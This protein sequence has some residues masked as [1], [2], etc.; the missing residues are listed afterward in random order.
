MSPDEPIRDPLG[1]RIVVRLPDLLTVAAALVLWRLFFPAL[2]SADTMTQY[3]QALTRQYS[4]W[5]PVFMSVVLSL[6]LGLGGTVGLFM[7]FQCLA[8]V[9]GIRALVAECLARLHGG[10]MP[11]GAPV[12]P[13]AMNGS[14]CWRCCCCCCP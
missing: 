10:R 6:V 1:R 2:M 14:R 12:A 8:G 7:L 5:H 13:V 11:P 4:D 9:F 3:G